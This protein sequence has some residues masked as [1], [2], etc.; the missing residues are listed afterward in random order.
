MSAPERFRGAH[1]QQLTA[2]S[3]AVPGTAIPRL[4]GGL[5]YLPIVNVSST[6]FEIGFTVP[7]KIPGAVPLTRNAIRVVLMPL[8]NAPGLPTSQSAIT[9]AR[10]PPFAT[11]MSWN[12]PARF[13]S[14][15]PAYFGVV[16]RSTTRPGANGLGWPMPGAWVRIPGL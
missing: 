8:P 13:A 14:G 11:S 12:T 5:S 4:R 10:P 9:W 1:Q 16:D 15:P 2:L 6:T 7:F 3:A